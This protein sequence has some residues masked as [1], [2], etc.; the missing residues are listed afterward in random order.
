MISSD[1]GLRTPIIQFNSFIRQH[2]GVENSLYGTLD[3]SFREDYQR[4]RK[5]NAASNFAIIDKIALNLL[6]PGNIKIFA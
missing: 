2:R 5:G 6:K 3:L 1:F 4:K